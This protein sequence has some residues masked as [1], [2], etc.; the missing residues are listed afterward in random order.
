METF[1]CI[2][3]SKFT[4]IPYLDYLSKKY[5][6]V[7]ED[8]P[9]WRVL[10]ENSWGQEIETEQYPKYEYEDV[11]E[12]L[13]LREDGSGPYE[14]DI[15]PQKIGTI[16]L[17]LLQI[18][19]EGIG[20]YPV[21]YE[22]YDEEYEM[23]YEEL[24]CHLHVK[25]YGMLSNPKIFWNLVNWALILVSTLKPV[26]CY[27]YKKGKFRYRNTFTE[28]S[29][30]ATNPELSSSYNEVDVK[31]VLNKIRESWYGRAY[32][33]VTYNES[34]K[35]IEV[36][37]LESHPINGYVISELLYYL[38]HTVNI[39]YVSYDE[40]IVEDYCMDYTSVSSEVPSLEFK[41]SASSPLLGKIEHKEYEVSPKKFYLL[42]KKLPVWCKLSELSKKVLE[43]YFIDKKFISTHQDFLEFCKI[44]NVKIETSVVSII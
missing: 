41:I 8:S 37:A 28:W 14:F 33:S 31:D 35:T 10:Y 9:K 17:E 21:P 5:V 43:Y 4:V 39:D 13:N 44:K 15:P 25:V 2:L 22:K 29:R 40:Y 26:L 34:H 6:K 3:K 38:T 32:T 19:Y 18:I 23:D 12:Y 7:G 42:L 27:F 24:G 36:R 1:S 16:D 20:D 11:F 30:Y